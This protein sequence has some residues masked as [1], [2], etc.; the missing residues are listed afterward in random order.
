MHDTADLVAVQPPHSIEA[1]SSVLSALLMD[2]T[3][4]DR[5]FGIVQATHFYRH[6]HRL[7]FAA[8]I[9]LIDDGKPADVV[10]VFEHLQ[11]RGKADDAGGLA[12]INA[13]AQ[14]VPCAANIRRYAEIV[15]DRADRRALL[16]N[17]HRAH[18]LV[19]DTELTYQAAL[20]E[21]QSLFDAP[22]R[23]TPARDAA[24]VGDLVPSLIDRITDLADGKVKPGIPTGFETLDCLLGGLKPGKQI[25]I[26]ARPSVGKT[27]WATAIAVAASKLGHPAAVFSMEMQAADLMERL[28]ASIGRV[29]LTRLTTG[30]LEGDEWS[31]LTEAAEALRMLPLFIDDTPALGLADLRS[32][33][34]RLRRQRG[35][36]VLVLD[37]L[38]L[39]APSSRRQDA[40][41]HHQIE[42]LSRG[43]KVLA[44]QLELTTV[45]LSQLG[46]EVERRASGRPILADLKESGAIEEDADVVI[47]LSDTG[48][49]TVAGH[50]VIRAD[51][52]KNRAG[53]KGEFLLAFD[54]EHQRWTETHEVSTTTPA[55]SNRS[56]AHDF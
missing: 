48:T 56:Y 17:V 55:K 4:T 32:R 21:V 20:S 38:Q 52:A 19:A 41:R 51:V 13:L 10:T 9:E 15:R 43:L 3:A 24:V 14:Y 46:R 25:V 5:V 2:N 34:R 35:V 26:A 30:R 1:E 7:I 53:P 22:D 37:Y 47:L 39:A 42:E 44:K 16:T 31:R 49:T 40:G 11:A 45:V 28:T 33:A 27:S 50:R 23:D 18:E 29:G 36:Q 6:E 54:G 12:Y 8:L